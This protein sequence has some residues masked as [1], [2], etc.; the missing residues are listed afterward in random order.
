LFSGRR[1]NV[2]PNLDPLTV[3]G[4]MEAVDESNEKASSLKEQI[5]MINADIAELTKETAKDFE[6][7]VKDLKK[8]YKQYQDL[9]KSNEQTDFW[10]LVAKIEEALEGSGSNE[11]DADDDLN[12]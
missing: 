7:K 11:N 6:V 12:S 8:A 4:Y 10:E 2:R 1:L 5:K 3:L 9:K